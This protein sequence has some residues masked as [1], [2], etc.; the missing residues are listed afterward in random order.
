MDVDAFH[1]HH[2]LRGV[3]TSVQLIQCRKCAVANVGAIR[4]RYIS[5]LFFVLVLFQLYQRWILCTGLPSVIFY[6]YRTVFDM[7][8]FLVM[9]EGCPNDVGSC[10]GYCGYQ[11][12]SHSV[13]RSWPVFC[14]IFKILWQE[15]TF[16]KARS[17]GL[18]I[19]DI[20]HIILTWQEIAKE[21]KTS[22]MQSFTRNEL[23]YGF[24]FVISG[25]ILGKVIFH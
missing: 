4:S 19:P 14:A 17:I 13:R 21:R 3:Q 20:L 1:N 10:Y 6:D 5:Q 23:F 7:E 2:S 25:F 18:L 11:L 15:D 16:Q 9:F 12:N 24:I 22:W 8:R